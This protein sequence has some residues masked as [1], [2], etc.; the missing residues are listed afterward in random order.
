MRWLRDMAA[1]QTDS[2]FLLPHRFHNLPVAA[3]RSIAKLLRIDALRE[4]SENA[5]AAAGDACQYARRMLEQLGVELVV[6][7]SDVERIPKTGPVLIVANHPFGLLEGLVLSAVLGPVRD[8]YRFLANDALRSVRAVRDRVIGVDVHAG[9]SMQNARA[10]REAARW[11]K[12][13]GAMAVFP[14]GEVSSWVWRQGKVADP[15]WKESAA[16]LATMAGADVLPMFFQGG[17]SLTFH[18]AGVIHPAIRTARLPAELL[19]KR[20]FSV[21]LRIGNPIPAEELAEFGEPRHQI[22]HLRLRT[23]SL[24]YRA[25]ASGPAPAPVAQAIRENRAIQDEIAALRERRLEAIGDFEVYVARARAIPAVLTEIGRLREETFRGAGEGTGRS[26]DIDTFDAY[27]DHLFVWNARAKAIAGA[28]RVA[29]VQEVL[30][31]FGVQGL[32]TASLFQFLPPFFERLGPALELG[33][34]F[35]RAEYQREYAP[36]YLLWRG[37]ARYLAARPEIKMLFGAVSISNR[38]TEAS[39]QLIAEFVSCRT[40]HPLGALVRPRNPYRPAMAGIAELRRLA[41]STQSLDSLSRVLRDL[42]PH[43]DGVPVLLRQYEKLGGT[44]LALNVDTNFSE[45]LDCLLLVDLTA[46]HH[47]LLRRLFRRE[48]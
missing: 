6:S 14:S 10:F 1:E 34:S 27:Y 12:S 29:P 8:D 28:Y 26:S 41:H 44:V 22:E 16:R 46:A 18:L 38:Y 17:N 31:R 11:L 39:R 24:A 4:I 5:E 36:L 42:E 43:L 19:S 21:H 40:A 30:R 3:R 48:P 23:Y 33:R 37:I 35:I 15:E 20:G 13:G 7:P 47:P 25:A 2:F 9:A 32:Y 45:V